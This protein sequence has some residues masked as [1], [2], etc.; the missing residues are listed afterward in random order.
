M[1]EA[2]SDPASEE[3]TI[4]ALEAA[5]AE[6][7]DTGYLRRF[8]PVKAEVAPERLDHVRALEVVQA[9]KE[10]GGMR[11][12]SPGELRPP[13][14]DLSGSAARPVQAEPARYVR[15]GEHADS[16]G[17]TVVRDGWWRFNRTLSLWGGAQ[18]P[19]AVVTDLGGCARPS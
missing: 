9:V 8:G 1:R 6:Q 16:G 12:I 17:G 14:P 4:H 13:V 11:A 10:L 15:P 3:Q 18:P 5:G 2:T 19:L 7:V